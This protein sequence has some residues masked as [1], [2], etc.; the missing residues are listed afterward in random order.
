MA[1]FLFVL[2]KLT[3]TLDSSYDTYWLLL[4]LALEVPAYLNTIR[5]W[6]LRR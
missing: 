2:C 3:K 4:L 1:T 5:L 6:R